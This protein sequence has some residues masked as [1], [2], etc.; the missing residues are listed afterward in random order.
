MGKMYGHIIKGLGKAEALREAQLWL[1]DSKR[2]ER[3]AF[4]EEMGLG[5][6]DGRICEGYGS[7]G[8]VRKPVEAAKVLP[9][10]TSHPY[11]W[12]GF[13]CSGAP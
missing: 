12:A 1:R 13:I 7:S 9:A 11:Y 3:E 5:T 8:F 2:G 10:D 6:A 4:A